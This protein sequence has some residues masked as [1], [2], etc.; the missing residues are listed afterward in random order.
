MRMGT[1][2]QPVQT[3][4][5][6]SRESG[7]SNNWM[8][9]YWICIGQI[10]RSTT[11]LCS[12]SKQWKL[13]DKDMASPAWDLDWMWHLKSCC[14]SRPWSDK[15]KSSTT[16]PI[17]IS[18]IYSSMSVRPTVRVKMHLERFALISKDSEPLRNGIHVL[19]LHIW[20]EHG[21]LQWQHEDELPT[22]P[23][24]FTRHII[25]SLYGNLTGH[26]P[27]CD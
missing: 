17:R 24:I 3:C 7:D 12:H 21:R 18:T 8:L 10:C 5:L 26:L 6:R 19:G 4:V 11:S 1:H 9:L 25:F 14:P 20:E 23:N 16:P 22:A 13:R 2:T 27:V 15:M